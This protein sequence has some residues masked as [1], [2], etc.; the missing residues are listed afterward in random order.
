VGG[1]ISILGRFD[2][3]GDSVRRLIKP[4][5]GADPSLQK[6]Y[7]E[8]ASPHVSPRAAQ[9]KRI[10]DRIDAKYGAG[11]YD[12]A[13]RWDERLERWQENT[14]NAVSGLEDGVYLDHY[15]HPIEDSGT[16][17]SLQL[18]EAYGD[19]LSSPLTNRADAIARMKAIASDA[20]SQSAADA[21]GEDV[22]DMAQRVFG[23]R[24]ALR[25]RYRAPKTSASIDRLLNRLREVNAIDLP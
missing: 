25:E 18:A 4:G 9:Y 11:D 20:L 10:A 3:A 24:Q 12:T 7:T 8:A 14:E 5:V 21:A 22:F 15:R 23:E 2:D 13:A 17:V 19:F 6:L 16:D 1:L